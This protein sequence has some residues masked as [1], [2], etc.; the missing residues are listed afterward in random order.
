MCLHSL[1]QLIKIIRQS[2]METVVDKLI[3]FSGGKD[4]ELRDISGLGACTGLG[5]LS[6]L[7]NIF[8]AALKTITAE[9]PPDGKIAATACAKLTPKLLGQIESVRYFCFYIE[10]ADFTSISLIHPLKHSWRPF[11]FCPF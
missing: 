11:Q 8:Y 3:D 10:T 7:L 2:Q 9:L 1:G 5:H 4:E 6:H